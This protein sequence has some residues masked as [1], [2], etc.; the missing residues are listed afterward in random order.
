[1]LEN[2]LLQK[3]KKQITFFMDEKKI[4]SNIQF[5]RGI[6]VIIVFFFH[7]NTKIFNVFFVGVDI[8]F[9]YQVL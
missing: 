8:F 5:L 1:M 3:W 6:S 9:Y 4:N 7:F 2:L